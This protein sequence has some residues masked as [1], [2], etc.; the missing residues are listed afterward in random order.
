MVMPA[1]NV[2]CVL[3][4]EESLLVECG[5][6]LI[7]RGFKITAVVA[8]TPSISQWAQTVDAAAI[9]SSGN[10]AE[11]LQSFEYDWLFSIAN[12]KMLPSNVWQKAKSAAINFHDGPLPHYAG[13]NTPAWAIL[14]GK[15]NHGI[16]WHAV[17]DGPDTGDIYVQRHFDIS[18]DDTTLT[19][20]TKCFQAG[21]ESFSEVLDLIEAGNLTGTPQTFEERQYFGLNDRPSAGA[22]IDFN[23]STNDILRLFRALD[24]GPNYANQLCLPKIKLNQAA[25][26]VA[27]GKALEE[28]TGAAG[29]V[30]AVTKEHIDIAT[31]D[32]AI[33]LSAIT[34]HQ[35]RTI[36]PQKL[37]Q[38][39]ETVSLLAPDDA[40]KLSEL[41]EKLVPHE[42]FF[43]KK[44]EAFRDPDLYG[45]KPSD[46]DQDAQPTTIELSI[47]GNQSGDDRVI[48]LLA[49]IARLADQAQ[50]DVAY[51]NDDLAKLNL[52]YPGYVAP[53]LPLG[54]EVTAQTTAGEFRSTVTNTIEALTK[55]TGC[56][57]DLISKTPSL[58][59]QAAAIA[60]KQTSAPE[61][62]HI[63]DGTALTFIVSSDTGAVKVITDKNR[64]SEDDAKSLIER[65]EIVASA[66]PLD[67][68]RKLVDLPLMPAALETEL[69]HNNNQTL[70]YYDK[71]ALINT[72]IEA[73]VSK[74][75]DATA[76]TSLN[77]SLTYKELDQQANAV[78]A[79]LIEK[80]A[81]PDT[82]V[83]IYIN[84]S[85]D[86]V[87][88]ALGILK[89]GAAYV[90]LDPTYP[91]DRVALMIEDSGL[92]ILLTDKATSTSVPPTNDDTPIDTVLVEDAIEANAQAPTVDCQAQPH[93][94]AYV[95]YTSGST[96]RPKGVMVEHRN[97]VNFFAGM[98]DRIEIPEGDQPV[99]L[100]VTSLSFDISV[101][102]LFWTLTRGF[103]TVIH[104]DEK[105]DIAAQQPARRSARLDGG[106]GVGL[107]Y[108]GHDDKASANKYKL[109]LESARFA[110]KNGFCAIWTPERHFHAFGGP[111]PNPAVT[112]A[113]VASITSNID[114]R[115]GSCV[116]PLH[117]PTRV[118]EEWSVIDNITGG[119]VGLAIA[120][121]WMPED[122]LLRPE[123]APPN[124]KPAMLDDIETL[125]KL[126]RGDKVTYK[127]PI[128]DKQIE[129]L[130]QP[131]PVQKEVPLW[132]TTAG[133][134]ESF[135]DAAR[136]GTNLLTHLLGQSI[137]ELAEKIKIYRDTLKEEGHNPDDFT[138]TLML[139]TFVGY[140]RE[141]VREISR[142]PMKDYLASATALVKEYAWAFPAFK[143]P[144]G[145]AKPMDIDLG[146][147]E[148][149]EVE[150]ILEF[151]F[152]R[153][154]EDSGFFGTVDDVVARAEQLKEIG[155]DEIG[156]LI[157]FG[158]SHDTVLEALKP[159]AEA[160]KLINPQQQEAATP[161]EALGTVETDYSVAA[162]IKRHH[163]T[164][165]QCTPSM[166]T[167]LLLNEDDKKAL[168]A[169][170]HLFIGGEALKASL[171]GELRN[172]TNATIDNM[173]GP[174]E[175][176]IW[177]STTRVNN[178]NANAPLG[179]AIANTQLYILDSQ[180][181]P[182]PPGIPGELLI[183]GDGVTRGYLNRED[184]TSERFV[185]NP[186]VEGG[187]MYRTGDL[188]RLAPNNELEFIGRTDHQVKVRGYRI[189]LG[190]I[191]ARLGLHASVGEAVV[192]ARED[193]ANDVRI[194]AY[195]RP[196]ETSFCE[197][198]LTAH[199]Q[200]TLPDFMIPAHFVKMDAFPLTPNAKVDRKALPKPSDVQQDAQPIEFIVPSNE[201][202]QRIADAFK[203]VLGVER[204]GALDNFFKL[205][206]HSLLA[207]Q[208]HRDLKKNVAPDLSITDIY[209]FP[210]VSELAGHIQGGTEADE[211]L[212]KVASRAAMRRKA[213]GARRS[214]NTN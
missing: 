56:T 134:P 22:T 26:N 74:T 24:F 89:A 147:L 83:G 103:K 158:V 86:L 186:F 62:A 7:E 2:S 121:G 139:H 152:M 95:I 200:E 157:D 100:A 27:D 79:S 30:L 54:V 71:T 198:T 202:Q 53:T 48:A 208:V 82:L 87:V 44:L 175:T 207:V 135:R 50:L 166:A 210:S 21:I 115:A 45:F 107:F 154:F 65:I 205:G 206:G 165:M 136:K 171:I 85:V 191:E 98:D 130:T 193:K 156:C 155:V 57:G 102:E 214:L 194:V 189:E 64:I 129:V 131:R 211:Q 213:M 104:T 41:F 88:A 174:T 75:P 126:W 199:L 42:P 97:V 184:L 160:V 99:W 172:A 178:V 6:Q 128:A 28:T 109:L 47:D 148:E 1:N 61:A 52:E 81:G 180:L 144:E 181:R 163:V 15:E 203:R 112:G 77:R 105:R 176:T 138:V 212:S 91:S 16:T 35:G 84:R 96:G 133:N 33:R 114:I 177:S 4:G 204:V 18:P 3:I 167:M 12:L 185:P 69:L 37:L 34:D 169:V 146:S 209:R 140:D 9:S 72:L 123:N 122:F 31:A 149:D 40:S 183:G 170:K 32:G 14:N 63:V 10:F 150:A 125:R 8:D 120:A 143:K 195:I 13:L 113:A 127:S 142:Q 137:P 38:Q 49:A 192:I 93:N 67:E 5:S 46:D 118:A 70:R 19:L 106:M 101:L 190:E 59:T 23:K 110:D 94:L 20:N 68:T 55:K 132:L 80:G 182:V 161:V 168:S 151:A 196:A 51:V 60:I 78:A 162:L 29:T 39:G 25:Y 141:E 145:I 117:H 111:Y 153:Y 92:K 187:R 66:F 36:S 197:K 73:Q 90:P 108:W 76:V 188:V 116:L 119:R 124:N 159:L 17:S 201:I 164:H 58:T 179:T 173:Y 43:R 11:E